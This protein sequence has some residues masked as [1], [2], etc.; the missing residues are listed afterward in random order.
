MKR[1]L[2]PFILT[3]LV[4]L[5]T[6][7]TRAADVVPAKDREYAKFVLTTN[8]Q[9]AV[10]AQYATAGAGTLP[11][12]LQDR[13]YQK[14]TTDSNSNVA[15]RTVLDGFSWA[16]LPGYVVTNGSS[17]TLGVVTVTGGVYPSTSNTV[18]LGTL[19]KPYRDLYLGSNSVYMGGVRVMSYSNNQLILAS[20]A[21]FAST[22]LFNSVSA[23][24]MYVTNMYVDTLTATSIVSSNLPYLSALNSFTGLTNTFRNVSINGNVNVN[25]DAFIA[26]SL[27]VTNTYTTNLYV[28][29]TN[30]TLETVEA[31]TGKFTRTAFGSL[32]EAKE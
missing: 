2:L 4:G 5:T 28:T 20:T 17:P 29:L 3:C 11:S 27:Y 16:G 10:R 32:L 31:N 21:T 7:T 13:E 9:V 30:V 1:H 23:S 19:A 12:N 22:G 15:V 6:F 14:F 8:G 18:D 26:R 25:G 24:N